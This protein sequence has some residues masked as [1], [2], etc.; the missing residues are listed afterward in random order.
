MKL[1]FF[2]ATIATIACSCD[3]TEVSGLP[4]NPGTLIESSGHSGVTTGIDPIE[5]IGVIASTDCQQLEMGD[6]ACNFRLLDQ[7][8]TVWD[9]YESAGD[10]IVLDFS[11]GWCAP[12]QAAGYYTQ[13]LQDDYAGSGVQIVTILIDGST[14][15]IEP[16][17]DEITT[18][19]TDHDITTAPVLLGSRDKVVD[20]EGI[21]GYPLSAWPTYIYIGR[22]MKFYAGHVGFSEEYMR[23]M[24]DGAL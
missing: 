10:I 24:I 3:P 14:H 4:E 16:T 17:E 20:I 23:Q 6:K 5:P 15:T 22:D 2:I 11:A 1:L 8:G 13:A 12:C 21:E 18:W 9:L 19:V 7:T